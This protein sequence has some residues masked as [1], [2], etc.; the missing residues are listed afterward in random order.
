M[1]S[2]AAIDPE[3]GV[4]CA[5]IIVS[6]TGG[7]IEPKHIPHLFERF[8]RAEGAR[9]RSDGGTGLGLSI[10]L[11]IV[12]GHG[13]WIDVDSS[14]GRGHNLLRYGC[15]WCRPA[16]EGEMPDGPRVRRPLRMLR[17]GLAKPQSRLFSRPL[18]RHP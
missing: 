15:H 4:E 8:Y 16:P 6:D 17:R 13:G 9:T 14:V 18:R 11:S 10:A 12:R 5:R 2:I 1:G 7:G 3:T